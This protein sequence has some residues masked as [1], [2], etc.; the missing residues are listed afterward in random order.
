MLGIFCAE[1]PW[2]FHASQKQMP[3]TNHTSQKSKISDDCQEFSI[4]EVLRCGGI[5]FSDFKNIK[6]LAKIWS[7]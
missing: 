6:L 2:D 7:N 4:L 3:V 1:N 5:C